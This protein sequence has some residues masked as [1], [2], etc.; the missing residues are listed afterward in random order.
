[1][2]GFGARRS[3]ADRVGARDIEETAILYI[4][5]R[6]RCGHRCARAGRKLGARVLQAD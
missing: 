1:M 6:G 2:R 3:K 4:A 5:N